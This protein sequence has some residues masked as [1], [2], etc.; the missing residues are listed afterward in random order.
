MVFIIGGFFLWRYLESYESTDDA[1]VDGHLNSVTPRIGGVVTRVH[2]E[3]N[4]FVKAGQL[5]V[6]LDPADYESGL[7][8]A[9]ASLAQAEAQARAAGPEVPIIQT[10]QPLVDKEEISRE[11]FDS[12]IAAARSHA[13][14]VDAAR[15]AAAA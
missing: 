11:Q 7:T 2:V 15:S 13:A 3:N 10:D 1:Q 6:E 12:M 9:Q 4:Q 14:S 8:Q 5:L